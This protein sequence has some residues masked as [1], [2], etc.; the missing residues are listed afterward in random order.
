MSAAGGTVLAMHATTKATPEGAWRPDVQ[1]L[2]ALAVVL[3]V[4]YHS[5]PD[6]L[7]GGFVGVDIFFVISGFVI[8]LTLQRE[9]SSAGALDLRSFY[10]R[11]IRRILPA[12][13]A[14]TVTVAV[15]AVFVMGVSKA[16]NDTAATG[17]A[18]STLW[19]NVRL[20]LNP[21]GYFDAPAESNALL[22]TWSLSVE[23]QFYLFFPVLMS[24]AFRMRRRAVI[25]GVAAAGSLGLCLLTTGPWA[26]YMTPARAW[27]FLVGALVAL[28]LPRLRLARELTARSLGA[29]GAIGIVGASLGFSS[30]TPFPGTA[31]LVP[32]LST[33]AL[34]V[35]GAGSTRWV[36]AV[37]RMRPIVRIGDLSYGWYLW[38]WPAIVF[39]RLLGQSVTVWSLGS[40]ALAWTSA[41]LVERPLR[42]RPPASGRRALALGGVCVLLPALSAAAI[43]SAARATQ[44]DALR[45]M[46]SS[47]S[48]RHLDAISRC[49]SLT[50][51]TERL[52]RCTWTTAGSV[53]RILLVGDSNAGHFSE[54]AVA[55]GHAM[56]FDVSVLTRPGCPFVID[57]GTDCDPYVAESLATIETMA[58]ELVIIASSGGRLSPLHQAKHSAFRTGLVSALKALTRAGIRTLLVHQVPHLPWDPE[59]CQWA[60]EGCWYHVG[61]DLARERLSLVH[62]IET[63]AASQARVLTLDLFDD[64][65]P[66]VCAVERQGQWLYRDGAHL[67]VDFAATLTP[68]FVA[69]IEAALG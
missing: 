41:T 40:L 37:L 61:R 22:H 1:G 43:P 39:A 23:E 53:G 27:E 55:A 29:V 49:D 48:A 24:V 56:G 17:F 10:V 8:T 4:A 67:S 20:Y 32:V 7:P 5:Q 16:S 36:S 12:L 60:P 2:R 68:R 38:H 59:T 66:D 65:C 63:S 6:L 44:S 57:L 14:M 62:E 51:L 18:A 25:L 50:P 47:I 28:S 30:E 26:F 52:E 46:S 21:A 45:Q 58:P 11:R 33:A 15:A 34:L 13:A 19:A 9:F 3:V 64:V 42:V 31:A 69:A 35:A 54:P